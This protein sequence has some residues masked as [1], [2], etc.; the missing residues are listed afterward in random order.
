MTSWQ[1][2]LASGIQLA[3]AISTSSSFNPHD[4][5]GVLEGIFFFL[6][7]VPDEVTFVQSIVSTK[8]ISNLKNIEFMLLKGDLISQGF[9]GKRKRHIGYFQWIL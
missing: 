1:S 2:L 7:Q 6:D 9:S 4:S 5:I 8:S 3:S